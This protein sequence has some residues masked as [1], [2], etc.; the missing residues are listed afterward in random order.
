MRAKQQYC[1]KL[2]SFKTLKLQRPEVTGM[3]ARTVLYYA[4]LNKCVSFS[5]HSSPRPV[6]FFVGCVPVAQ[7]HTAS[8]W[9]GEEKEPSCDQT[10]LCIF[11]GTKVHLFPCIRDL[12]REKN[13]SW[14]LLGKKA[15]NKHFSWISLRSG[16]FH[17]MVSSVPEFLDGF[18][19]GIL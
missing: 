7:W 2:L 4:V 9:K 6:I 5:E 13:K 17:M 10:W 8:W 16:N 18:L 19:L 1:P 11:V 14:F 15:S 3:L 12:H